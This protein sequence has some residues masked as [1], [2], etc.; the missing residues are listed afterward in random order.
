MYCENGMGDGLPIIPPTPHRVEA[1]LAFADRP[2][3]SLL[4]PHCFPSGLPLTVRTLA[5]N[6]VM[7]GCRAEYLPI[8]MTAAQ[9]MAEPAYRIAQASITSHPAGNAVLIS[10]PLAQDIGLG[11]AGGCLGPGWR[12]NMT[13]GRALYLSLLNAGRALPGKTD[14]ST[15]GSAAKLA[16]CCAENLQASPWSPLHVDLF[17]ADTTSVTVLKCESPHNVIDRLSTTGESL[18]QSIADVAATLGGNNAYVAAE[19]LVL[20]NPEHAHRPS[21]AG[22]SKADVQRY[23]F[24]QARNPRARLAGRG[25]PAVRP[26]SFA[27]LA[28]VPVVR[29]PDDVLVMVVG[30]PGPHSMVGIPWGYSRA[31]TKAVTL[32]NG[33]A[34]R[35]ISDFRRHPQGPHFL[36]TV[37]S[38]QRHAGQRL[39]GQRHR[40]PGGMA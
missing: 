1:M 39:V 15:I 37:A 30:A 23:L 36:E 24:E 17:D 14:L 20:L 32:H 18:L 6:A 29:S 31:V 2:P 7:A 27:S 38:P 8:L 34:A 9:A 5:I 35:R 28:Q 25:V 33:R 3:D 40:Q 10:G 21:A 4:I 11:S 19:L 22:W 26:A 13:I 12:A 16:F